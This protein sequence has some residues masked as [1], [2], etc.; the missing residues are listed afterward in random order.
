VLASGLFGQLDIPTRFSTADSSL[1]TLRRYGSRFERPWWEF[2]LQVLH[3]RRWT[4][5]VGVRSEQSG[6]NKST[7]R[8]H[9][10]NHDHALKPD[11][12][13]YVPFGTVVPLVN[14]AVLK[15]HWETIVLVKSEPSVLGVSNL[16][17][18]WE[19]DATVTA[20]GTAT[21]YRG[22][23]TFSGRSPRCR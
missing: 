8:N 14:V 21:A 11:S 1:W 9:A 3:N 18:R 17:G 12:H 15:G 7:S 20:T 5:G 19:H 23:L 16:S 22:P 2:P 10:H 4:G 13:L 6:K